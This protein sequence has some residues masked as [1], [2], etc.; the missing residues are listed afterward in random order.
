[1][2]GYSNGAKLAN[3]QLMS[4][5]LLFIIIVTLLIKKKTI[6]DLK[7]AGKNIDPHFIAAIHPA[8]PLDL[9]QNTKIERMNRYLF[10]TKLMIV[11]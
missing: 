5:L 2:I 4:K 10:I 8:E 9:V 3:D 11:H 6:W 1:M 7:T